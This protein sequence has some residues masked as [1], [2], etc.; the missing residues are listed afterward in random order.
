MP[1]TRVVHCILRPSF[2]P[3]SIYTLTMTVFRNLEKAKKDSNPSPKGSRKKRM[4]ANN[5]PNHPVT[6]KPLRKFSSQ[7]AA[8]S[9]LQLPQVVV[10]AIS[11]VSP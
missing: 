2:W 4:E 3:M 7:N 10:L 5:W 9:P 8:I 1:V 6:L 11:I